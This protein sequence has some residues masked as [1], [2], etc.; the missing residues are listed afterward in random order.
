MH[1]PRHPQGP[2]RV[3]A[4]LLDRGSGV[5]RCKVELAAAVHRAQDRAFVIP[6]DQPVPLDGGKAGPVWHGDC[7]VVLR[8]RTGIAY[9]RPVYS[10][11]RP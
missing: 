5:D 8:W 1:L 10:F 4:Y 3:L 7:S 6:L 2:A 9:V 11:V